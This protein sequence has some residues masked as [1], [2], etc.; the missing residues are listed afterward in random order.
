MRSFICVYPLLSIL[1]IA[2]RSG[3]M[4][5]VCLVI[6]EAGGKVTDMHG[7]TLDFSKEPRFVDTQGVVVSNGEIH[8]KVLTVL[9]S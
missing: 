4:Q 7:K 9:A 3:I 5:L 8:D 6:E 1:A 2:K